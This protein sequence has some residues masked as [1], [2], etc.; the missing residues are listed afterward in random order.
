M[1][2]SG[3]GTVRSIWLTV[4]AVAAIMGTSVIGASAQTCPEKPVTKVN[5][6][7]RSGPAVLEL[8]KDISIDAKWSDLP[9]QTQARLRV[10]ADDRLAAYRSQWDSNALLQ[11]ETIL[12][13]CPTPQMTSAIDQYYRLMF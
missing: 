13:Q 3:E 11:K 6:S 12:L 4:G 8:I 10:L 5:P 9:S 2:E 1:D 7:S